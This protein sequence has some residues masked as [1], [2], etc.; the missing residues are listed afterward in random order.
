M[1]KILLISGSLRKDSF[2]TSLANTFKNISEKKGADAK[3]VT[4]E[5]IPFFNE[6][7]EANIPSAVKNL[8]ESINE[9]DGIIIV[10]PEYDHHVP[11]AVVNLL[12]WMSRESTGKL[13]KYKKIAIAGATPGGFGTYAMQDHLFAHLGIL[14][15]DLNR[16]EM[17][18][19]SKAHEK[20]K[21]GLINDK[22]SLDFAS[23]FIENF[24]SR[25]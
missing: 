4:L 7:L 1:S 3:V 5:K 20:I 17:F 19:L 12:N 9:S 16:D 15:A 13:F 2:N 6:D 18:K 8:L 10:S 23:S 24:I 25:L 14:K 11:G 21:N 22:E